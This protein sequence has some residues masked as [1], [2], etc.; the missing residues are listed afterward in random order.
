MPLKNLLLHL[1][2]SPAMQQNPFLLLTLLPLITSP[3]LPLFY[4]FNFAY[5]TQ[6]IVMSADLC[7]ADMSAQLPSYVVI[8]IETVFASLNYPISED[9]VIAQATAPP[10]QHLFF[11]HL[12]C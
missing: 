4:L 2:N 10:L 12:W 11:L 9:S 3:F 1:H 8:L 6:A 7:R 5:L